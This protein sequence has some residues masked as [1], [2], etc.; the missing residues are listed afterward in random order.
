MKNKECLLNGYVGCSIQTN[1]LSINN[2]LVS[3]AKTIEVNS[4]HKRSRKKYLDEDLLKHLISLMKL[5]GRRLYY[6]K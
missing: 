5:K 6:Y 3:I 2:N 4:K 1:K